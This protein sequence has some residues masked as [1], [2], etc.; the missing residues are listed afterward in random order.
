MTGTTPSP[1]LRL[2]R[3]LRPGR[4]PLA[5]GV[6]RAE[7]MVVKL[8]VLLALVLVP[9]MLTL[10]S[11]T[12]DSLD[13]E[14]EQQTRGRHETVAVLTRNGP[15]TSVGVRGEAADTK[16]KVPATWRLPD[17]TTRTGLVE[18]DEGL[19]AGAEVSVWLDDESGNP[20]D[21]PLS[22][23][24]IV[25]AAVLVTFF[26]WSFAVGMLAALCC[27]LH[28]RLDRRRYRMWEAEWARGESDWHDKSR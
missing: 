26:G 28:H 7:A 14:R 17:G 23:V 16:S 3:L 6:D 20:T 4:N 25:G 5:R 21:A 9:I 1:G 24:D 18:A 10:G 2:L 8:S 13:Q 12:Y 27:G 11:L 22:T 19:Q 15:A